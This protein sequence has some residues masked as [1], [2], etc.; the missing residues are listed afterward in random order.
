MNRE[1]GRIIAVAALAS[2]VATGLSAAD[3]TF[4]VP[5]KISYLHPNADE[6]KVQCTVSK[7]TDFSGSPGTDQ[8]AWGQ[9][10]LGKPIGGYSG[11][12]VVAIDALPGKDPAAGN[13]YK[14]RI[15]VV[16]SNVNNEP[17]FNAPETYYRAKSGTA[18]KTSVTGSVP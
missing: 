17:V 12:V 3:F 5:V 8:I 15:L 14:C 18:L 6:V 9:K 13:H 2:L 16:K 1:L 11:T 4:N 7:S 10:S